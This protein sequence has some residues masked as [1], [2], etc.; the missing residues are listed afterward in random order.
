LIIILLLN[1]LKFKL[2]TQTTMK[3]IYTSILAVLAISAVNAQIK[4]DNT[5][6]A[7][8]VT[9]IPSMNVSYDRAPMDTLYYMELFDGTWSP[10]IYGSQNGGYVIGSN[11]YG[12]EQKAQAFMLGDLHPGSG[13]Y[14][15]GAGLWLARKA[16]TSG[17]PNSG[18]TVKLYNMNG[19]GTMVAGTVNTAPNSTALAQTTLLFSMIDTNDLN[20]VTFP[21]PVYIGAGQ[22]YAIGIDL[23][24]LFPGDTV[25]IVSSVNGEYNMPE[26]VWEKWAAPD[27]WYSLSG[28]GWGSGN[29]EVG[30]G[31]LAAVDLALGIEDNANIASINAYPNPANEFT[32]ISYSLNKPATVILTVT[33]I[34][35]KVVHSEN[36][37][38]SAAGYGLYNL[39]TSEYS[40]GSYFYTITSNGISKTGKFIV[41]R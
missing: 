19:P 17:N 30:A 9:N 33:D 13:H 3:K 14:V 20:W 11:G 4:Q 37:N 7:K 34:T 1:L 25:G 31:V 22:N 21:T 8:P 26:V 35:G 23:T 10:A 29:F 39:N 40:E 15:V 41:V 24:G 18:I 32:T 16:T 38:M 2:N 12:D 6:I 28:A 5:I 27:G 36:I